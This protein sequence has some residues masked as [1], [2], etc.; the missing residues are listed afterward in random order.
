MGTYLANSNRSN[1]NNHIYHNSLNS[2]RPQ[3]NIQNAAAGNNNTDNRIMSPVHTSLIPNN[4]NRNQNN[5]R[6]SFTKPPLSGNFRQNAI[7]GVK[8]NYQGTPSTLVSNKQIDYN[9]CMFDIVIYF[10]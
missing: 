1:S 7:I 2:P 9:P 5:D 4:N 3:N 6:K 10:R 8:S